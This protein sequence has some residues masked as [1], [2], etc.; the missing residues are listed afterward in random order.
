MLVEGPREVALEQLVVVDGLGDDPPDKLEI[1]EMVGVDV[2]EVVDG[3]G[4]PVAGAAREEGLSRSAAVLIAV[5]WSC[6]NIKTASHEVATYP[7][8]A[9]ND[10]KSGIGCPHKNANLGNSKS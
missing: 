10:I 9:D 3:V 2:A 7:A 1:A 5:M 4:D 6:I 8:I